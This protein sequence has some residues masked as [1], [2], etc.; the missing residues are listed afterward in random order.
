MRRALLVLWFAACAA[1]AGSGPPG[2]P[3]AAEFSASRGET[4]LLVWQDGRTVFERVARPDL[5]Q[6]IFSITKS[7]I[8]IGVFRDAKAGGLSLTQP[9]RHRAAQGVVLSDL[10][11]QISGLPA[12]AREF[13]SQGLKDKGPLLGQLRFNG[14]SG[15]FV[16]G[17][18]HWEILAEEIRERRGLSVD[19][20][21]RKFVPGARSTALALWTRDEKGRLFF[22][23][24]ARMNASDLVPAGREVLDGV[25]GGK[26]PAEVRT[27]LSSGTEANRMYALGFWLNRRAAHPGAREID[28]EA[29][30][31][32]NQPAAFWRHACLCRAAPPD[33][34]AMIGTRGQRVYVVPSQ[35]LVVIRQG[36]GRGFSDAEFLRRLFDT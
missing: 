28:V 12:M 25:R 21:V 36:N 17:P 13:Y 5:P 6:R 8:S 7:L 19:R 29:A 31:G 15:V 32:R 22:S 33:L 4:S 20:W 18:S 30:L 1:Q 10:L 2:L 35:N 9:A 23:T 3:R 27:M 11:N 26:W 34:L 14:P 24:G 16:Y